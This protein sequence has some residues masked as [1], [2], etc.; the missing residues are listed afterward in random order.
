MTVTLGPVTTSSNLANN[1]YGNQYNPR[2][3]KRDFH[4]SFSTANLTYTTIAD[5]WV[6]HPASHGYVGGDEQDLYTSPNDPLFYLIH[7]Q[8]D[9]LWAVWQGQDYASREFALDGTVTINNMPPSEDATL[10]MI[11]HLDIAAGNDMPVSDAMTAI[12]NDYCYIYA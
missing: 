11:M 2:C 7:S 3:L 8:I 6:A 1:T 4:Q 12:G 10:S 5:L 9:R